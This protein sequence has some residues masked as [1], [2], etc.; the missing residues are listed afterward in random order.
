MKAMKMPSRS[1]SSAESD[2][3]ILKLNNKKPL[4][5]ID[6]GKLLVALAQDYGRY[7]RGHKLAVSRVESGSIQLYFKDMADLAVAAQPYVEGF[8]TVAGFVNI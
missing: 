3:I 4:R 8:V 1:V 6:L 5:S 2:E 7:A